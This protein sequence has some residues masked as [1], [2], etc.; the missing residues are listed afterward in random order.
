MTQTRASFTQLMF[1]YKLEFGITDAHSEQHC[2][3][4]RFEQFSQERVLPKRTGQHLPRCRPSA[5]HKDAQFKQSER[6]SLKD[7]WSVIITAGP[8][9]DLHRCVLLPFYFFD[10]SGHSLSFTEERSTKCPQ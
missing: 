10:S 3:S 9:P 5:G 4:P 8:S 6:V 7:P 2:Q 1:D